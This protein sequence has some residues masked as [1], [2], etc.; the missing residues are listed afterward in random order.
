MR[1]KIKEDVQDF[2]NSTARFS[3]TQSMMS[4]TDAQNSL[5]NFKLDGKNSRKSL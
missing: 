2:N 4:L 1:I 3:L 5:K